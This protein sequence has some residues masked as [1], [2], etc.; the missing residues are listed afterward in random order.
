MLIR[1]QISQIANVSQNAK[2]PVFDPSAGIR[3]LSRVLY[4][5]TLFYAKQSQFAGCPND[6]NVL[7]EQGLWRFS[8]TKTAEKQSQ[9]NPIQSQ[10]KPISERPKMN[11]TSLL[12]KDYEHK[13]RLAT[14]GKQTQTKP[15]QS[16]YRDRSQESEYRIQPTG[17]LTGMADSG[18]SKHEA[19]NRGEVIRRPGDQEIRNAGRIEPITRY[20]DNHCLVARYPDA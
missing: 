14:P 2:K 17:C 5:S 15:N 4:K 16:Q 6:R 11:T 19:R 7:W 13:P 3:Q 18:S 12:A 10:T 1:G 8:H 9:T 20:S